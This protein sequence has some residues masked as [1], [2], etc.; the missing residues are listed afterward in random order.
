MKRRRSCLFNMI[1]L[2]AGECLGEQLD[3]FRCNEIRLQRTVYLPDQP[4]DAMHF[5]EHV[6][7]SLV[8]SGG[9][10]ERK[11]SV[12][13]ERGPGC[14]TFYHAGEAHQTIHKRFP[15]Q[16]LNLEV[17]NSWLKRYQLDEEHLYKGI[18]AHPDAALTLIKL[19]NECR[20]NDGFSA[21]SMDMLVQSMVALRTTTSVGPPWVRIIHELLQD[22]WSEPVTLQDLAGAAGV[23]P[24]TV[25]KYFPRYFN[26]TLGEYVRKLR[27]S[28]ALSLI[29]ES[30]RPLAE[31]AYQCGFADQSHMNRCVR[32]LTGFL[33]GRFRQL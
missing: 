31:I 18:H 16:H 19:Y 10:L 9:N 3:A 24:V 14:V 2:E 33:P 1:A 27:V 20:I 29:K 32:E 25:S 7:I 17:G 22:R 11:K 30:T 12:Q 15:A 4:T 21:A 8:L 5:H 28:R 26:C 23:H 13:Y 6:H